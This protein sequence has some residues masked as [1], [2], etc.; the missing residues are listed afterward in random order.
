MVQHFSTFNSAKLL[1]KDCVKEPCLKLSNLGAGGCDIHGILTSSQH[2]MLIQGTERGGVDRSLGGVG[3]HSLHSVSI[4]QHAGVVS[5]GSDEHG[6]ILA[7]LHVH[8]G[9]AV[10]TLQ[11]EL[12]LGLDIPL[13]QVT[14]V[15]TSKQLII[16]TTPQH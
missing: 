3:L 4:K 5:A 11:H 6:A 16:Q 8:D 14:I 13:D 7:V 9:L 15:M 2:H 10:V 12:L 1:L